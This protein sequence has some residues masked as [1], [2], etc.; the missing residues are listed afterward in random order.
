MKPQ[1]PKFGMQQPDGSW[2]PCNRTL[3]R[4]LAQ[5]LHD[6]A[7]TPNSITVRD[8]YG[9]AHTLSFAAG[10]VVHLA[11]LA[12]DARLRPGGC[13]REKAHELYTMLATT[14]HADAIGELRRVFHLGGKRPWLV[15]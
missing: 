15:K 7:G 10:H 1:A 5:A 2:A 3:N 14:F 8:E 11:L 12:L 9:E 6:F 4:Q 13:Y